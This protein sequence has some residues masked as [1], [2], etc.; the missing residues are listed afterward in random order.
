MKFIPLLAGAGVLI[1]STFVHGVDINN[2]K[3]LHEK[4][5]VRCHTSEIYTR[6]NRKIKTFAQLKERI[7]QCELA[8][9]LA[10]FEEDIND[11]AAYLNATYYLFGD[12]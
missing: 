2:G 6:N 9:E 1:A 4:N 3:L 5:C 8:N 7:R 12:R 11:V 10:W